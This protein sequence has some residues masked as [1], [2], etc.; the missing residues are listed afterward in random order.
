MLRLKNLWYIFQD[1][2]A[3]ENNENKSHILYNYV[4]LS[5]K[6]FLNISE[7]SNVKIVHLFPK[8]NKLN[9]LN[10]QYNFSPF[11]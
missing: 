7:N 3:Y 9:I 8:I 2:F 5:Y 4:V 1:E 11:Y 6:Q 10:F